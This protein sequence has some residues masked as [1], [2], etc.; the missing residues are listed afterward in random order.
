MKNTFVNNLISANKTLIDSMA[1]INSTRNVFKKVRE[2]KDNFPELAKNIEFYEKQESILQS[3]IENDKI[4]FS[5]LN[6]ALRLLQKSDSE[7]YKLNKELIDSVID[8][9]DKF[10]AL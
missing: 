4:K 2:E 10:L 6:I 1:S 3:Y 8:N 5:E 7:E 9:T